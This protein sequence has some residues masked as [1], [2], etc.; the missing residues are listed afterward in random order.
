VTDDRKEF[1]FNSVIR[2]LREGNFVINEEKSTIVTSD[3]YAKMLS[4]AHPNNPIEIKSSPS[5]GN[6]IL[7][8]IKLG[9]TPTQIAT[10]T[11]PDG[12]LSL[13]LEN[14]ISTII[15]SSN[16]VLSEDRG[17]LL[18]ENMVLFGSHLLES[19]HNLVNLISSMLESAA[20]LQEIA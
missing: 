14:I 4:P 12:K 1:A 8:Q 13:D 10:I 17:T 6:G 19:K 11:N 15:K 18:L 16:L 5:I 9:L 3:F 7:I 20:G 2:W